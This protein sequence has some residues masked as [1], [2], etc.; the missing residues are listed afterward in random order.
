MWFF[1]YIQLSLTRNRKSIYSIVHI[2]FL[3]IWRDM[4]DIKQIQSP[5]R[6]LW[7]SSPKSYVFGH[8]CVSYFLCAS[9]CIHSR[10]MTM[11]GSLGRGRWALH[12]LLNRNV[13]SNWSDS[14]DGQLCRS[15]FNLSH[16]PSIKMIGYH[17]ASFQYHSFSHLTASHF[18]PFQRV[19]KGKKWIE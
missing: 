12:K 7:L 13:C 14:F 5:W 18:T 15:C 11:G 1:I 3:A 6:I 16:L 9:V 2:L 8:E 17:K 10:P 19:P 4:L